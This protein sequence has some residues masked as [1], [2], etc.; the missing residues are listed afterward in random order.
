MNDTIFF[1]DLEKISAYNNKSDYIFK[2][3][4]HLSRGEVE[5]YWRDLF[6]K[7]WKKENLKEEK[8]QL[9]EVKLKLEDEKNKIKKIVEALCVVSCDVGCTGDKLK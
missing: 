1:S 2:S 5:V 8:N 4:E 3:Q 6:R 7:C 9:I